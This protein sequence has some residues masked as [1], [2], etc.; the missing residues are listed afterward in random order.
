[1]LQQGVLEVPIPFRF[2]ACFQGY[3]ILVMPFRQSSSIS[4][5]SNVFVIFVAYQNSGRKIVD[6]SVYVFICGLMQTKC[7]AVFDISSGKY[8]MKIGNGKFV[9]GCVMGS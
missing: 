5:I 3:K 8:Q 6:C 7:C 9:I 4:C 1:M 2:G